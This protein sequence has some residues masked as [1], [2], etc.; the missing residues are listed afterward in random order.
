[1]AIAQLTHL[2]I[3][4]PASGSAGGAVLEEYFPSVP[5]PRVSADPRRVSFASQVTVLGVAPESEQLPDQV[6]VDLLDIQIHDP[7]YPCIPEE[8]SMDVSAEVS[9]THVPVL[10]PPPGF[11]CFSWPKAAGG[12]G[13]DPSL[14]D[15]S[16]ELPGWFP[17]GLVETSGDPPSLP[18]SPILSITLEDSVVGIRLPGL[19][20]CWTL[21]SDVHQ[22][23]YHN[24]Y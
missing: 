2:H 21:F 15:F 4:I 6:P 8:D 7:V 11:V 1:M 5:L 9:D 10:P 14:F 20:A 24:R 3:S 12:P 19:P 18:I 17:M 22:P 23:I 16:M 13:G